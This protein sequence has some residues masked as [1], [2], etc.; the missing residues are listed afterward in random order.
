MRGGCAPRD[1]RDLVVP[2]PGLAG[3]PRNDDAD[4]TGNSNSW[5]VVPT[6][7][8]AL[9]VRPGVPPM[10]AAACLDIPPHNYF[11]APASE[12]LFYMRACGA[13]CPFCMGVFMYDSDHGRE[14]L[15]TR[16]LRVLRATTEEE[17]QGRPR[18]GGSSSDDAGDETHLS[19]RGRGSGI[20]RPARRRVGSV[21]CP[22]VTYLE[23]GLV[24]EHP[25]FDPSRRCRARRA[26]PA[27]RGRRHSRSGATCRRAAPHASA[28]GA[29]AKGKALRFQAL[30]L[31]R[32][33]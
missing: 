4:A 1:G 33:T 2:R 26:A 32:R 13:A 14:R 24:P 30:S 31:S 23:H 28:A 10:A 22:Y 21:W 20:P 16:P 25:A 29:M 12:P 27:R 19:P 7:H 18:T 5:T 3:Q 9:H 15:R 11:A 6:Q 17:E 8:L